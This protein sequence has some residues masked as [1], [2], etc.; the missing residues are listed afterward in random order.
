MKRFR[1]S[2]R[3]GCDIQ[4]G[5]HKI[6]VFAVEES[7]HP[8]PFLRCT[9][10]PLVKRHQSRKSL[11][12]IL[13]EFSVEVQNIKDHQHWHRHHLPAVT[14]NVT[15]IWY[16]STATQELVTV[17]MNRARCTAKWLKTPFAT[18]NQ[19]NWRLV[20][21]RISTCLPVIFQWLKDLLWI[22]TTWTTS[23]STLRP[24]AVV[25]VW[26]EIRCLRAIKNPGRFQLSAAAE[27]GTE[28][29][30][31]ANNQKPEL[32]KLLMSLIAN[33]GSY[34]V[35]ASAPGIKASGRCR[36]K[37]RESSFEF[38][39]ARNWSLEMKS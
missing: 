7:E 2:T 15:T 33:I 12:S 10:H 16:P 23:P 6:C 21:R 35:C 30:G 8:V 4:S 3:G 31:K 36:K 17:K 38:L 13:Q 34:S 39:K 24:K 14:S 1:K 20:P 9:R 26:L 5:F 25:N 29:K 11:L 22:R 27:P 32:P 37:H 28:H 19:R 18:W